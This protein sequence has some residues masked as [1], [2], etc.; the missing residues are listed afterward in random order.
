VTAVTNGS[1][2]LLV[3][4]DNA[5]LTNSANGTIGLN[6]TARSNEVQLVSPSARWLMVNTLSVG[7]NGAFNRLAVSNGAL[8][9]NSN[10]FI[11]TSSANSNNTV[12]VSGVGSLWSNRSSLVVGQSGAGNQL[13]ISNGGLVRSSDGRVGS[14][15]SDNQAL[16]TGADS[17][18][19][20]TARLTD[21]NR[22]WYAVASSGDGSKL[23]AVVRGGQIYTSTDSGVTWTP[24]DSNRMWQSVASSDN[25]SK[26]VAAVSSRQLYA[27]TAPTTAGTAG[28]L[29]GGQGAAIELE[30]IGNNQFLALSHQGTIEGN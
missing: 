16:V 15:G 8:V 27:S 5:L 28:Y 25:G 6:T 19:T 4:S 30:Y 20:W 23:V 11:G 26:L 7:N 22:N 17:G 10:A 21:S 2:T 24:R 12:L 18:A 13:V 14:V 3:L 1:F 29:I 9:A